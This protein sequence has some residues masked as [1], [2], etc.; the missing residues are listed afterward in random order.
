[1]DFAEVERRIVAQVMTRPEFAAIRK[2]W[3]KRDT[4]AAAYGMLP[5]RRSRYRKD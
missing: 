5:W 1:M 4:L 2:C 3:E